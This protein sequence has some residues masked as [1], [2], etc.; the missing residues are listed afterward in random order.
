MYDAAILKTIEECRLVLKR[1]REQNKSEF[2]SAVFKRMC[3]LVGFEHD[4]PNDPM[5]RDF[6][7]NIGRL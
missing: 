5:V 1:A 4:D 6:F 2:Y 3:F 7:S